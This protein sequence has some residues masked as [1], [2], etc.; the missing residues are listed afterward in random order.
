MASTVI[1]SLDHD[2]SLNLKDAENRRLFEY[3]SRNKLH[4][5]AYF[6]ELESK[7]ERKRS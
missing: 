3:L 4:V 7:I 6:L 5:S 2:R 1:A